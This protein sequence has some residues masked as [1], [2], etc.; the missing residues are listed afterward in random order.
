[1]PSFDFTA[2]AATDKLT[3]VA[4]G[5]L[6]G[7]GPCVPLVAGGVAAGLS[8]LNDY[9]AIKIDNDN[10]KL[11]ASQADA[12]A[13]VPV[14][15]DVTADIAG[16]LGIGLP[17]RRK[18]TYVPKAAS[19][20]GSTVYSA[21]LNAMQDM[22]NRG[23]F[24][25]TQFVFPAS[26]F[27]KNSGAAT[28]TV[29]Q[30]LGVGDFVCPLPFAEGTTIHSLSWGYDHKNTGNNSILLARA[31]PL[32]AFAVDSWTA[33]GSGNGYKKDD[34][35]GM[36]IAAF[37]AKKLASGSGWTLEAQQDNAAHLFGGV[38]IIASRE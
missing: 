6:S 36:D 27:F 17:Y 38:V 35:G 30:W 12:L 9:W 28:L 10:I 32:P 4:H 22:I 11:A 20:P 37:T 13:G 5:L 18:H 1:M 15:V 26:A 2:A 16:T 25:P 31:H 8:W 24:G 3:K 19:V 29:G 14:A 34:Y 33:A 23:S 7:D 21:D